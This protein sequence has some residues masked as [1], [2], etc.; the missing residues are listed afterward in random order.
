MQLALG[1]HP[2]VLLRDVVHYKVRLFVF[3]VCSAR[4][5]GVDQDGLWRLFRLWEVLFAALWGFLFFGEVS[6]IYSIIGYVLIIGTAVAKWLVAVHLA[7]QKK[8]QQKTA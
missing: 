4:S 6:D 7:P 5:F 3:C 8:A 1:L 2:D